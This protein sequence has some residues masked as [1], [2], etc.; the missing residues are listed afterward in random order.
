MVTEW[1]TSEKQSTRPQPQLLKWT[2]THRERHTWSDVYEC[3]V[4]RSY[5]FGGGV[6]EMRAGLVFLS[7]LTAVKSQPSS[8][9]AR[10]YCSL[11]YKHLQ[12]CKAIFALMIP[13]LI[14]WGRCEGFILN[15]E[16]FCKP[17]CVYFVFFCL[18]EVSLELARQKTQKR[19]FSTWHMLPPPTK[20]E[21]TTT[22]LWV[23]PES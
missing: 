22:F 20:E 9:K 3:S 17:V 8:Q 18:T 19:S 6:V 4:V 12:I 21:K 1:E 11:I 10:N 13:I 15:S 23:L 2:V 5:F 7:Y 14:L 16:V